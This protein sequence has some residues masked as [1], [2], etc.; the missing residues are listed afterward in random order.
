MDQFKEI[1]LL[2]SISRKRLNSRMK[3]CPREHTPAHCYQSEFSRR[4]LHASTI[5]HTRRLSERY[6]LALTAWQVDHLSHRGVGS[7][8]I[9]PFTILN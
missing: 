6:G 7:E 8:Y 5:D 1:S 9:R 3:L 2:E 4:F